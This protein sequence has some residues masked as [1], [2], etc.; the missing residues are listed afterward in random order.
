MNT[1]SIVRRAIG[2]AAIALASATCPALA[3]D[4]ADAEALVLKSRATVQALANDSE[5][6]AMKT[7]LAQAKAVFIFPKVLKAGFVLG[8]SGGTGVLLAHDAG[9]GTW[10]G[11]AFYTIGSASLGLQAGASSAEVVMV[12][13]SQKALDSLYTNKLKIGA[14]ATAALGS[15]GVDKG[16]AINADFVVYS[17]AKGAFAG[18][19]VDGSV[20]D[21]RETLNA[22][23]YGKSATPVDILVKRSV[24]NP[25]A[26]SLRAAVAEAESP[27]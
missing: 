23:Y 19:A 9:S 8:G 22:A 26:G 27:K 15:K 24:S 16:A 11:P 10:I 7:A 25:Q 18:I 21:V 5:F 3:S 20:L 13:N 12:V 6:A 14:E 1:E 2:P 4:K 17:K